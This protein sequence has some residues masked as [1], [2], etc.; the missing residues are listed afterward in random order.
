MA[1]LPLYSIQD[2]QQAGLLQSLPH[3]PL[4]LQEIGYV[5]DPNVLG[6]I[7]DGWANFVESGQIYAMIGGFVL[8]YMFSGLRRG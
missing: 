3:S 7:Q 4:V 6:Q 2:A 8:G 1:P 5:R